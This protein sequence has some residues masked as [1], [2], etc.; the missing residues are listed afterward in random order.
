[1]VEQARG[2]GQRLGWVPGGGGVVLLRRREGYG[3]RGLSVAKIRAAG[4]SGRLQTPATPCSAVVRRVP[5][6]QAGRSTGLVWSGL[7]WSACSR[8]PKPLFHSSSSPRP[9]PT[10]TILPSRRFRCLSSAPT[11]LRI[12]SRQPTS[13]QCYFCRPAA[14]STSWPQS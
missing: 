8:T 14:S 6:A 13:S 4:R 11:R 3:G 2:N 12:P 10:N 7:V 5:P 9:L 1:M